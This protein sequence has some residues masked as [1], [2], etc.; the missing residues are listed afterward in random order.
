M[1][2]K[3]PGFKSD[4]E[5]EAFL[6]QGDLSDYIGAE[7]FARATFEFL[8]KD[9]KINL[10]VPRPLLEAVKQQAR[11]EGMSYQKYIRRVLE[12]S[13]GPSGQTPSTPA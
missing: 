6:E 7:N 8:P 4:E 12:Q 3:I 5:A 11:H 1:S 13:V 2:R 10:R 9:T